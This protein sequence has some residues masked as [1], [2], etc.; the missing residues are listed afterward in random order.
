MLN[1]LDGALQ[2]SYSHYLNKG[3]L[4]IKEDQLHVKMSRNYYLN[5][6]TGENYETTDSSL[7][8]SPI[9]L[10]HLVELFENCIEKLHKS[11]IN[12]NIIPFKDIKK[13]M[14]FKL[15]RGLDI[16]KKIS[17]SWAEIKKEKYEFLPDT[18]V[19]SLSYDVANTICIDKN[20]VT[21]TDTCDVG[22]AIDVHIE[23]PFSIYIPLLKE[24][25]SQNPI[26]FF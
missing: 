4:F 19:I 24:L 18:R 1:L 9:S 14:Y 8:P 6:E 10:V 26:L 25:Y 5:L 22:L 23:K 7:I 21:Y 11:Y 13:G 20:Y 17:E 16:Y 2:Y 12:N 15:E 3:D